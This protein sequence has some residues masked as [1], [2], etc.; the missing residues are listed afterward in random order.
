[1]V[2][3][4]TRGAY[5]TLS[6]GDFDRAIRAF[7]PDAVFLFLGDHALGGRLEGRR[8]I[9]RWFDRLSRVF[10]DLRLDPEVILVNGWPWNTM[11]ATRFR[12]TATLPGGRTY[13][14]NGMQFIRLRW[15]R[16]V[17][18]F[19]Y[20]DTQVLAGALAEI[21]ASG[22]SEAAAAPLGEAPGK[23]FPG[24]THRTTS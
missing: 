23:P 17:E 13:V 6:A 16:I 14:N 11:V 5:R 22:N 2:R 21:A 4:A 1:M 9:G 15:G 7:A 12:A 20:E 24:S 18:D 10:P 19:L 3:R 8:L